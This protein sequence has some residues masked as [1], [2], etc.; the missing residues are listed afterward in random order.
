MKHDADQPLKI[1][2]PPLWLLL[3]AALIFCVVVFYWLFW[4]EVRVPP[5]EQ[6]KLPVELL[7]PF[8]K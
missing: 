4:G 8:E 2:T 3:V 1:V 5:Q 7:I 6:Q